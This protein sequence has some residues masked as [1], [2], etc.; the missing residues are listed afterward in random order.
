[1]KNNDEN[2]WLET[3]QTTRLSEKQQQAREVRKRKSWTQSPELLMHI[4]I[5]IH[6]ACVH[7]L[8][9]SLT[10]IFLEFSTPQI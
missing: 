2:P 3:K 4:F 6:Y 10:V 1:M 5:Y 8:Y 7:I 9:I